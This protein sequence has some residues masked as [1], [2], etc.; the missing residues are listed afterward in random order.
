V[1]TDQSIAFLSR[2]DSGFLAWIPTYANFIRQQVDLG[3]GAKQRDESSFTDTFLRYVEQHR[4][5][6]YRYRHVQFRLSG[7]VV[8]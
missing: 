6:A 4:D 3:V 8:W 1:Q 5:E 2:T 7:G